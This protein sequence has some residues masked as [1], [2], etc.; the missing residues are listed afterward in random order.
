MRRHRVHGDRVREP[1]PLVRW[2]RQPVRFRVGLALVLLGAA[3]LTTW[4]LARGGDFSFYE[5]SAR[6][7]SESWRALLFG[8]FDPAA[9]VTLDKLSGFAVPQAASIALFGMT[10]SAVALPQALEGLVTVW[11]CSVIGLRW[12]GPGAGLV[13]GAAA[14]STPILVSMFAHPMEDGLLTMSLAVALLSWQRAVISGRLWPLLVAG[15]FVGVGFQAKMAQAW[16]ILPALAVGTL[17]WAAGPLRRRMRD[18]VV[19]LATSVA[20]SVA[21]ITAMQLVPASSRPFIDGST[22]DD[23][24]A[25]VFG[26]NGVDRLIP[27]A[28]PGAVGSAPGSAGD[29]HRDG[30]SLVSMVTHVIAASGGS[31][32]ADPANA[33]RSL[34][35]LLDPMYVTQIGWLY[36]AAL[37]AIVLSLV[38]WWRG[39]RDR[40]GRTGAG[41]DRS[42]G[43]LV[44]V[45]TIWLATAAAVL[46]V[47][48]VPHTAYVA[49][50]AVQLALLAAIGWTQITR[51]LTS[52]RRGVRIGGVALML[53][54]PAWAG[55]LAVVGG[56][57]V[58]LGVI[59]AVV[60]LGALA[61]VVLLLQGG[62]RRTAVREERPAGMREGG[63]VAVRERRRAGGALAVLVAVL[64]LAGPALW[65]VQVVDS[66]REGSGGDAY[67]GIKPG[68]TPEAHGFAPSVPA[69]W[70]GTPSLNQAEQAVVTAASSAGGGQGGRPLLLSDSWSLSADIISTTGDSVLTDGGYSGRVTVFSTADIDALIASGQVRVLAVKGTAPDS[71]PVREASADAQCRPLGSFTTGQSRSDK[72]ASGDEDPADQTVLWGCS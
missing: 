33:G 24:F 66:A 41:A 31:S 61:G 71:D 12:G 18:S 38:L 43:A 40:G 3:V 30:T 59:L 9:T 26:Y 56:M 48:A 37:L 19:L 47:A 72:S 5:A 14:A 50:I 45:L 57:P 6:S 13:A 7:M 36:P 22:D 44:I 23:V 42:R 11:A 51:L 20:A 35:K 32:D 58:V 55:V 69:P 10:T 4:N 49:A 1:S 54:T 63:R 60:V 27:G 2:W 39:R 70:G 62:R 16:F 68:S 34:F 25:M 67:V 65:S 15:L 52:P 8:A 53:V 64:M 28:F 21:W 46:T 17:F 29:P